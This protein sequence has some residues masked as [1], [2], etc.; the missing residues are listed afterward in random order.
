M[1]T[2]IATFDRTPASPRP[3]RSAG[4]FALRDWALLAAVAVMWGSSF[5]LIDVGLD[6]LH[7]ATV[8]WLRLL[9]GA[10]TLTCIPAARRPVRR[11]DGPKVA[12]LGLIWMAGPFLLFPLAQQSIASSLAGMINGAAP[13]FTMVVAAIWCRRSPRIWQLTGLITGFA[14]VAAINYP[15]AQGNSTMF[16]AG[17]VLLATAMYGI[18]F[19]IA[20][21]LEARNG[22]LPVIWRAEMVALLFVSP[23]GI[24]GATQ[25][26]FAWSSMAAM[27][28]LGVFST[29]LAFAAF[30]TL[31]GRV[32][33]PRGSVTV[34]FLPIV[35]IVLGVI[36]RGEAITV[37]AGVGSALVLGGA[38]LT[39]RRE[40]SEAPGG[41]TS[42]Q[43]C[44]T[45][46]RRR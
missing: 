14:G 9:F 24:A 32:G 44:G 17:L 42:T 15:A 8:A 33:A 16:G 12:L 19:N 28:G 36:V 41:P 2:G 5:L 30:T 38:Y 45:S 27:V 7:P 3:T 34:Y 35:A 46:R 20:D 40:N 37:M 29:G 11:G 21:P 1:G 31:I 43:T 18:A 25:S 23:A 22:A 10:A 39:S 4:A 6:H 26:S 13:L